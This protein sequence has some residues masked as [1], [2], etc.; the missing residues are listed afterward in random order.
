MYLRSIKNVFFYHIVEKI[1]INTSNNLSK[2]L[3][4]IAKI[5]LIT[6]LRNE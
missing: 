3:I 1:T 5:T 4:C 6:F 2:I